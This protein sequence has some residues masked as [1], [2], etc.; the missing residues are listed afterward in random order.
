M[1][2]DVDCGEFWRFDCAMCGATS[3]VERCHTARQFL[4]RECRELIVGPGSLAR[5]QLIREFPALR[6]RIAR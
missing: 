2:R 4:C 3:N 5:A 6:K 1:P